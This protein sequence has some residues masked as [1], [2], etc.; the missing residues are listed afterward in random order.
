MHAIKCFNGHFFQSDVWAK[1]TFRIKH[2]QFYSLSLFQVLF[3]YLNISAL[4]FHET[5]AITKTTRLN[6]FSVSRNTLAM[7]ESASQTSLLTVYSECK[8]V[9]R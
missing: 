6:R 9:N 5:I 7:V 1:G 2:V 3:I 4:S 8:H